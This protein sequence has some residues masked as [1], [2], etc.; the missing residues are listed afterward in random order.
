MT[1]VCG[2]VTS[3]IKKK[4]G[5]KKRKRRGWADEGTHEPD[6]PAGI[7]RMSAL[8]HDCR[9]NRKPLRFP[10]KKGNDFTYVNFVLSFEVIMVRAGITHGLTNA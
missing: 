4:K 7:S 2:Q 5:R 3:E 9:I 8:L 10:S 6:K 1:A